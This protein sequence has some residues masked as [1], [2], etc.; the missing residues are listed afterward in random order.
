MSDEVFLYGELLVHIRSARDLPDKE[1]R[2]SKLWSS[3]DV[4]DPYVQ[5][6]MGR[7]RMAKTR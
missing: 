6:R 3:S 2:L 1:W 5:V 4:T 7:A